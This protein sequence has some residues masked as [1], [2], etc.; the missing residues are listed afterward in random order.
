M[1]FHDLRHTA[2]TLLVREKVPMQHVQRILRHADIKLTVDTYGHL[3]VEDL[4]DSV[5]LLPA[6]DSVTAPDL[7]ST[8]PKPRRQITRRFV[9]LCPPLSGFVSGRS[10]GCPATRSRCCSR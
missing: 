2:A 7:A 1:R 6:I 4:H 5:G 9:P 10:G 8:A 3:V